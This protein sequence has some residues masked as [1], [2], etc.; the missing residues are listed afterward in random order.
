MVRR[1]AVDPAEPFDQLGVGDAG[2][3]LD[4]WRRFPVVVQQAVI[5]GS[6]QP[7]LFGVQGGPLGH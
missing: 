4:R 2:D 1:V 6:P 7:D 5:D 3:Q